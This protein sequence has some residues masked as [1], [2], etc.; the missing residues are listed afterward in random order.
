M[1]DDILG[2]FN[3]TIDKLKVINNGTPINLGTWR[4][5]KERLLVQQD[6]AMYLKSHPQIR[7]PFIVT[8]QVHIEPP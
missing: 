6:S 2:I 5:M 7:I 8:L 4:S 3:I 1:V